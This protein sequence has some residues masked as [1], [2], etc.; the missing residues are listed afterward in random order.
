MSDNNRALLDRFLSSF[1]FDRRLAD[2]DIRTCIAHTRMLVRRRL[3]S[4]R[5]AAR[6]VAALQRL[7]KHPERIAPAEDIHFALEQ[8][9][10]RQ[11][12]KH[13][14]LAGIIRTGRSR[15][16]LVA[17]DERLHL[18]DEIR[19]Q[20]LLLQDL[21]AAILA[22]AK[23]HPGAAMCGMTHLQPA[24]P[25]LF[26]HYL[27]AFGWMFARDIERLDDCA[28]RAD[29]SALGAA[30][31]AGT[32]FPVDRAGVA[33][34]LSFHAPTDNSVDTVSDRDYYVE[35]A[36]AA[37]L[38]MAHLSRLAEELIIWANPNFGYISLP[39]DLTSGSSI[40]PQKNNPDYLELVRG[41]AGQVYGG[42]VALLTML[43]GLPLAYNRDMQEDKRFVFEVMDTV[44]DC[45]RVATL[46]VR[47][48]KVRPD[49][50]RRS[51]QRDEIM[52]T[53]LA[54]RLVRIARLPFTTAHA[55][56]RR[57]TQHAN[58]TGVRIADIPPAEF[59]RLL[60]PVRVSD[61]V[62]R[63]LRRDLD[64]EHA[65]AGA[66]SFGGSSISD[67]ERQIAALSKLASRK[68]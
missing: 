56:V 66:R 1:T 47:G 48:M 60:L 36:A 23:A 24:Q 25:V 10:E 67:V 27:L 40:M 57:I 28:R 61:T 54:N 29:R 5:D 13:R 53:E 14:A 26:A 3:V 30:A 63:G 20:R 44:R 64:P 16:D 42:L 50:M 19:A 12:G 58:A 43:K 59:R 38:I 2:A 52:A 37:S 35:Y 11:L 15:N 32:S 68:G 18:R 17:A 7:A 41:R 55:A 62:L 46:V 33:R 31:F 9:L 45:V 65:A 22:Q 39:E 4:A 21:I 6:V 49:A 34:L 51:L 8:A